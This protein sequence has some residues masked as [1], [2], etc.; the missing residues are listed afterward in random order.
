M[1]DSTDPGG[2]PP[3]L[4]PTK[5]AMA[6]VVVT[7]GLLAALVWVIRPPRSDFRPAP[8][9]SMPAECPKVERPFVPSNLTEISDPPL[10]GLTPE[11]RARAV[12][13][14]NFEPC[15]CGCNQSI[16]ECRASH[17]RCQDC[18]RLAAA[19]VDEVNSGGPK[20]R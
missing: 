4:G 10:S 6:T 13:R 12:Y 2:P 3:A 7:I 11:A 17:P 8:L 1:S 20:T 14:M 18:Q 9:D 5:G 15:P 19:I 16:A